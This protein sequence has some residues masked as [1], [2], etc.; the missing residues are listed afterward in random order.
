MEVPQKKSNKCKLQGCKDRPVKII[1]DCRYCNEKYCGK[2][3]LPEAHLCANMSTCREESASK[4][5]SKVLGEKCIG[6]KV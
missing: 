1:G 2:H 3:R 6:T 5:A 4:L